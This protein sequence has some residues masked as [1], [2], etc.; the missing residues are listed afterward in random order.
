MQFIHAVVVGLKAACT[1]ADIF[2]GVPIDVNS[3]AFSTTGDECHAPAEA[4]AG[5]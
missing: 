3:K 2:I 5:E 1:N 4:A